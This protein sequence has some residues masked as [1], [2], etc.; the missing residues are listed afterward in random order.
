[1]LSVNNNI[2][3]LQWATITW[4]TIELVVALTAG[5]N[6]HSVAL[7]AFGADS[8]IELVSA[9][10]VL[11]GLSK[12]SQR[13]TTTVTACMLVALAMYIL[14]S[15]T[16]SLLFPGL[17]PQ[18]TLA[19]IVLLVAAAC[20]MPLLARAKRR[21]ATNTCNASLGHDAIQSSVC[22]YLSIIAL[23]GLALNRVFGWSWADGLASF[24]LLP[25]IVY[26]ARSAFLGQVCC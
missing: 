8:A 10:A 18:T 9:S 14:V 11:Y 13:S 19:G 21:L 20:I 6:A 12:A 1:M 4:M 16:A 3:W 22:G 15:G 17:H 7:T 23:V 26:E 24:T 2:R 5:I 25:F